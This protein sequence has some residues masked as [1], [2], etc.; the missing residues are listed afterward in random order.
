MVWTSLRPIGYEHM[1]IINDNALTNI[2]QAAAPFLGPQQGIR[3]LTDEEAQAIVAKGP[4]LPL[5]VEPVYF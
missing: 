2:C 3:N 5:E 4:S 1:L